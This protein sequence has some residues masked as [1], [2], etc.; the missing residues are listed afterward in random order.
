M[1]DRSKLLET[2]RIDRDA[3]DVPP[4]GRR[5]RLLW[6]GGLLALALVAAL[7]YWRV[8]AAREAYGV[9]ISHE[10]DRAEGPWLATRPGAHVA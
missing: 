7:V 9:E 4:A 1:D 8:E 5:R 2:L 10:P 6:A 3:Q